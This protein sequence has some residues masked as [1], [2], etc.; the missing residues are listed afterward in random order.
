MFPFR[1]IIFPVDY[2]VPCEAIVPHVKE[3]VQRF[4]ADLTLVH[5]YGA[6]A[7][8]YSELS[9]TDPELADD[10]R[11]HEERRLREFAL[12]AFPGQHAESFA[13][14]GEAGS[15]I[16]KVVQ[17]QGTDLVMLPTHGRGPI[18]R[19]LLGSVTAKVLHDVSSA[20]WTGTGTTLADHAPKIPYKSVLCALDY[21]DEAEGVL[22]AGAAFACKY[23]AELWLVQIVETPP[24]TLEMGFTPY[25]KD[26]FDAADFRL[27]ELKGQLG[28]NAHHAIVN[29]AVADGIRQEAVRRKV[30]L[31]VTGRG[32][33]QATFGRM[34]SQLYPI[35]RESPCPVLS[36]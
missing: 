6:E 25:L 10:A 21:G 1:K 26:L 33:A 9:I 28:I 34:W 8:A 32:H 35:V 24:A 13:E 14:V 22:T 4:S 2:S 19:F 29:G 27:R 23:E 31:I 5:A 3:M 15:V 36:V 18:R 20:V 16:H 7:L 30:D 17:H 11:A 12:E